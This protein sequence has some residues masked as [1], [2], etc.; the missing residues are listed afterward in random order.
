MTEGVKTIAPIA[1]AEDAWRL[2]RLHGI[3]HLV[4]TLA[5]LVVGVLW[6]LMPAGVAVGS[7]QRGLRRLER[8]EQARRA[9]TESTRC[10]DI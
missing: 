3:H 4:V 6:D 10:S 2:M 1:M 9:M 8:G 5:N 7:A